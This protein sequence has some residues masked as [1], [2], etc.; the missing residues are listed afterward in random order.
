MNY[1]QC[2]NWIVPY[3]SVLAVTIAPTVATVI[4]EVPSSIPH[5]WKAAN[6][7][8]SNK[9]SRQ[10]ESIAASTNPSRESTLASPNS[11]S[12]FSTISRN[13]RIKQKDINLNRKNFRSHLRRE[14]RS[15]ACT[16]NVLRWLKRLE[17]AQSIAI[18]MFAKR[19]MGGPC[20]KKV[21]PCL[22]GFFPSSKKPRD[23]APVIPIFRLGKSSKSP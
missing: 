22:E 16:T 18:S 6:I 12:G 15:I 13:N 10:L 17:K 1:D 8:C 14:K 5:S 23:V 21:F 11:C 3:S 9:E 19:F 7:E 20:S 2:V 4:A